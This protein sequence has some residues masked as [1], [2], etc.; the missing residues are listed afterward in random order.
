MAYFDSYYGFKPN[1]QDS[2]TKS[3][4]S[5]ATAPLTDCVAKKIKK[6]Y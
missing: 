3:T 6:K 1:Y 4:I 2:R 5:E